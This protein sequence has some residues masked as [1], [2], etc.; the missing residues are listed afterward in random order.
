M[1]DYE[2]ADKHWAK[3][4]ILDPLTAPEPSQE[5]GPGSSH[6][7][8]QLRTTR[9]IPVASPPSS[10]SPRRACSTKS[11]SQH[12]HRASRKQSPSVSSDDDTRDPFTDNR[13]SANFFNNPTP[14][15]SSGFLKSNPYSA[16][17]TFNLDTH[18]EETHSH[19]SGLVSPPQSPELPVS[20]S[21][22][23]LSL[24][25]ADYH[26]GRVPI[27]SV[28]S[29][30][31][32]GPSSRHYTGS[33]EPSQHNRSR[34]DGQHRCQHH[35]QPRPSGLAERFPG[36]MSHRPLDMIRRET[37]AADRRHRKRVSEAD[38]IDLLDTIGPA[39]HHGGPYDATLASRNMNKMYS[40]VEAVRDSNMAALRATPREFIRDALIHHRP[41]QGTATVP[42]GALD[43]SGRRMSYEEG[44]DLMREPDAPGGAYRRYDFVDYHPDDLKGKGEPS[45][46]IERDLKKNSKDRRPGDEDAIEMESNPLM[47]KSLRRRKSVPAATGA[48]SGAQPAE[49]EAEHGLNRHNSAG[50]RI[51]E[52]LKRRFGSLR[53]KKSANPDCD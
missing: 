46:T 44:A 20:D 40:P 17:R 37:R 6:Y 22:Q 50:H 32:P 45:Y 7:N 47:A 5:T 13:T 12:H 16:R 2:P 19:R 38:T 27:R 26:S 11:N 10:P 9:P 25:T 28:S 39:Y 31:A 51:S 48:S 42:S 33:P 52:G 43:A 34:S 30:S 1:A 18:H 29:R 24:S 8:V 53:R 49:G 4:Y 14:P 35:S 36:D 15:E 3:R 21:A 23:P 41:L